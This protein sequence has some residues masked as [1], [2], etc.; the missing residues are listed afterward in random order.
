MGRK[1][2]LAKGLVCLVL[3]LP[4]A[5]AA[6]VQGSKDGVAPSAGRPPR[7]LAGEVK[8]LTGWKWSEIA[9]NPAPIK[10]LANPVTTVWTGREM[11]IWTGN[12]GEDHRGGFRK[13]LGSSYDPSHDS[14]SDVSPAPL[15]VR[16]RHRAVWTGKEMIIWG[17]MAS[18]FPPVP[19]SS[20]RPPASAGPRITWD[21]A[22]YDP[23]Q[24]TWR[25]LQDIPLSPRLNPEVI[26]TGREMVVVGGSTDFHNGYPAAPLMDGAAYDPATDEWRMLPPMPRSLEANGGFIGSLWAGGRLLLWTATSPQN[27]PT[28]PVIE[29]VIFD[30]GDGS[31]RAVPS[32]TGVPDNLFSHFWTDPLWTGS[33]VIFQRIEEVRDCGDTGGQPSTKGGRYDPARNVWRSIKESPYYLSDSG[34]WTGRVVVGMAELK[35]SH[36]A[37]CPKPG[38]GATGRAEMQP[39]PEASPYAPPGPPEHIWG[40]WSPST[41][42]WTPLTFP[43]SID[44]GLGDPVWTGREILTPNYR[45]GP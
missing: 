31:W 33:E 44:L 42:E 30:P 11:I 24:K 15:D 16:T 4:T 40:A 6:P 5:C 2:G 37:P 45:F 32:E 29:L 26:W 1:G 36:R 35:S 20:P 22:A 21:G 19:S 8:G 3:L 17:G 39:K 27:G 14:W 25:K 28:P 34:V 38:G 10:G 41:Q 7:G 9:P 12:W 23:E 13:T 43:P 18:L